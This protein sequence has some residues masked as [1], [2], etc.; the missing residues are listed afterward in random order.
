MIFITVTP[1]LP[2]P[3]ELINH[4]PNQ[5]SQ[6]ILRLNFLKRIY[7]MTGQKVLPLLAKN[8][9]MHLYATKKC[10]S[11]L[12]EKSWKSWQRQKTEWVIMTIQC[13]KKGIELTAP[14]TI[15]KLQKSRPEAELLARKTVNKWWNEAEKLSQQLA[16]RKNKQTNDNTWT[17]YRTNKAFTRS[18]DEKNKHTYLKLSYHVFCPRV[19]GTACK[20][21][22]FVFIIKKSLPILIPQIICTYDSIPRYHMG[23]PERM[24]TWGLVHFLSDYL[25]LFQLGKEQIIPTT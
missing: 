9:P 13:F 15:H 21:Y 17:I 25:S 2:V 1:R 18:C 23:P 4:M 14:M 5:R 6:K 10:P 12:S 19:A 24:R 3:M 22:F 11:E 8:L 20:T 7:K 16:R